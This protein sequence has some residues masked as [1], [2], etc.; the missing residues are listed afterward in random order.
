[1]LF[2]SNPAIPSTHTRLVSILSTN[3]VSVFVA[4]F[5]ASSHEDSIDYV[6]RAHFTKHVLFAF[7]SYLLLTRHARCVAPFRRAVAATTRSGMERTGRAFST[8]RS[9]K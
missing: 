8:R 6:S 5:G 2:P 1:M 3:Y 4:T 9:A 7:F